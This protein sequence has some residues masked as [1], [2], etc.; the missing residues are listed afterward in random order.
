[1]PQQQYRQ[2]LH[3]MCCKAQHVFAGI[4]IQADVRGPVAETGIDNP[5]D[6]AGNNIRQ[7]ARSAR[8]RLSPLDKQGIGEQ[9]S[10]GSDGSF[11]AQETRKKSN[12]GKHAA[13]FRAAAAPRIVREKR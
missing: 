1:V 9:V 10:A 6:T 8:H 4:N 13:G 12:R 7:Q 11:T 2:A 3:K 5:P